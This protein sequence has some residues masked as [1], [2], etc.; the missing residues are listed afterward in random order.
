MASFPELFL[1]LRIPPNDERMLSIEHES[2]PVLVVV[3]MC[4]QF[5][6]KSKRRVLIAKIKSGRTYTIRK[7][8][9]AFGI[10]TM[11]KLKQARLVKWA[12][13]GRPPVR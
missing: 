11:D 6:S 8:H 9:D 12:P 13:S 5:T 3:C 10:P 4:R 2:L 1:R 7:R